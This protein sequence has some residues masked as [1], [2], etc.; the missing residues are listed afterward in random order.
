MPVQSGSERVVKRMNRG[1]TISDVRVH[2]GRLIKEI[3]GI[4]IATH[5]LV[6]FPGETNQDFKD[7]VN[8]LKS[9]KFRYMQVF[10]Y[11]DRPNTIASGFKDKVPEGTKRRRLI[12]LNTK[13]ASM[14]T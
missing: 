9:F 10:K 6:G 8:F 14:M 3:P 1:Y 13:F 2:F 11:D 7:T 5:I 4:D 12:S